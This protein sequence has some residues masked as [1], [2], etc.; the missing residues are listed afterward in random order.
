MPS[1]GFAVGLLIALWP[2]TLVLVSLRVKNVT[3][4]LVFNTSSLL[5]LPRLPSNSTMANSLETRTASPTV[6]NTEPEIVVVETETTVKLPEFAKL[7]SNSPPAPTLTLLLSALSTPTATTSTP[8]VLLV[9]VPA[10]LAHV[11]TSRVL[12][13][14]PILLHLA[15]Q[16]L[17]FVTLRSFAKQETN[18]VRMISSSEKLSLA[19]KRLLLVELPAINL[20]PVTEST[21]HVPPTTSFLR[22]PNVVLLLIFAMSLR[23]A[24]EPP[25]HVLLTN[26]RTGP[27]PS[28]ALPLNTF[29]VSSKVKSL[30]ETEEDT[31]SVLVPT[32]VVLVLQETGLLSL[33]HNVN[34]TASTLSAPTTEVCPTSLRVTASLQLELGLV[35]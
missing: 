9:F 21:T 30:K 17:E 1:A 18:F 4:L 23:S 25:R 27:I 16:L 11:F 12:Q 26:V 28:S 7:P 19:V 33:G 15:E 5:V 2:Q 35:M 3:R 29:A 8:A 32:L 24:L 10:D 14:K 6:T 13:E 20:K 31:S 22:V 34:R